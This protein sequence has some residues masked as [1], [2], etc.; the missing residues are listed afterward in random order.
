MLHYQLE[1]EERFPRQNLTISRHNDETLSR[2]KHTSHSSFE[3]A[4]LGIQMQQILGQVSRA[5]HTARR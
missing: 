2:H 3:S 4:D 5:L 1:E